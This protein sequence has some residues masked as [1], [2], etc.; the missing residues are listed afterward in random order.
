M[1]PCVR[2]GLRIQNSRGAVSDVP[3]HNKPQEPA[4]AAAAKTLGARMS[5]PDDWQWHRETPAITLVAALELAS[6]RS[7]RPI[8]EARSATFVSA[9][10]IEAALSEDPRAATALK[11]FA[12]HWRIQFAPEEAFVGG[13]RGG[14]TFRLGREDD[15]LVYDDGVAMTHYEV[16]GGA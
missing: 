15:V 2:Q 10:Q 8:V 16:T 13:R 14:Y 3:P 7:G 1:R 12:P 5:H 11:R 4:S 9:T 6:R